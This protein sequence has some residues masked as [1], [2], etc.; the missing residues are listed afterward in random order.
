MFP[1]ILLVSWRADFNPTSGGVTEQQRVASVLHNKTLT[2]TPQAEKILSDQLDT[3]AHSHSGYTKVQTLDTEH[4]YNTSDEP[5][6][7]RYLVYV[8]K[9]FMVMVVRIV[10]RSAYC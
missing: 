8:E 4:C 5:L 10:Y 9:D 1:H 7:H 2:I 6:Y 3:P